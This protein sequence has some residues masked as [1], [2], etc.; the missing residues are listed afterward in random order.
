MTSSDF[1]TSS[2]TWIHKKGCRLFP[3]LLIPKWAWQMDNLCTYYWW[4]IS[5]PVRGVWTP[6]TALWECLGTTLGAWHLRAGSLNYAWPREGRG[7]PQ[8]ASAS[9]LLNKTHISTTHPPPP[10][11]THSWQHTPAS[12]SR[13]AVSHRGEWRR[14]EKGSGSWKYELHEPV[15]ALNCCSRLLQRKQK[16]LSNDK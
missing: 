12:C 6:C 13:N 2:N 8:S 3:V 14:I 9:C 1:P 10:T 15:Q 4:I 7:H 16:M 11:H 5:W